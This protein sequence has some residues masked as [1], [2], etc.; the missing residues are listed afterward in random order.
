[1]KYIH[2]KVYFVIRLFTFSIDASGAIMDF[3]KKQA[4]E[5]APKN[6]VPVIYLLLEISKKF[7]IFQLLKK[8]FV[9]RIFKSSFGFI[10][11]F[12]STKRMLK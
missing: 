6:H 8:F 12:S 2:K 11:V 1:M 9:S 4:F 7:S 5:K 3:E 10:F